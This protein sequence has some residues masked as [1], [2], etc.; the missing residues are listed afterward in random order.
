MSQRLL[1]SNSKESAIYDCI[2]RNDTI[3][4]SR[5]QKEW[6]LYNPKRR[7]FLGPFKIRIDNIALFRRVQ[8]K[9]KKSLETLG[10]KYPDDVW[11]FYFKDM[12]IEHPTGDELN[13]WLAELEELG[14]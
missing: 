14:E 5:I 3:S 1:I 13:N 2:I 12:V 4:V 8:D 10:K 6:L 9:I 11:A 7:V